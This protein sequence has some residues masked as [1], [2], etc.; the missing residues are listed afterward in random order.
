MDAPRVFPAG[1][2]K[3][4]RN[5]TCN[6]MRLQATELIPNLLPT[7]TH[8]IIIDP[9]ALDVYLRMNINDMCSNCY[10]PDNNCAHFVGHALNLSFGSVTCKMM[11]KGTDPG[12]CIRAQE[13]YNNCLTVGFWADRPSYA[14]NCL[15]FISSGGLDKENCMVNVPTKHVGIFSNG[16]IYH[17]AGRGIA[18]KVRTDKPEKW[19][20]YMGY[21]KTS[22]K[23]YFGLLP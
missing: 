7:V 20:A 4:E 16:L 18:G 22:T 9:L 10:I 13:I 15:A 11:S 3:N 8:V 21:P 17:H 5:P 2:V 6:A 1:S 23:M 12:V 14:T 19:I